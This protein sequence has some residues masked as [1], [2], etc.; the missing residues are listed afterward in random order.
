MRSLSC[1]SGKESVLI[2]HLKNI[3]H[4]SLP[5]ATV[6]ESPLIS[7][8][9]SPSFAIVQVGRICKQGVVGSSPIVSTGSD[10]E[11]GARERERGKTRRRAATGG[12]TTGPAPETR[13]GGRK[14]RG[15]LRFGLQ[16]EGRYESVPYR[17][18]CHGSSWRRQ[19]GNRPRGQDDHASHDSQ[20]QGSEHESE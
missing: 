7:Q 18:L 16:L 15:A 17:H 13:G 4:R 14:R 1:R 9:C 10:R 5:S 20:A 11:R 3:R 12:R 19:V 2:E 8:R 6:H